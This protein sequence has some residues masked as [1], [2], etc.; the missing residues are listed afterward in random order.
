MLSSLARPCKLYWSS[1]NAPPSVAS[2]EQRPITLIAPLSVVLMVTVLWTP[3]SLAQTPPDAGVLQQQRQQQLERELLENLPKQAPPERPAAPPSESTPVNE[4]VLVTAYRFEGNTRLTETHLQTVVAPYLNRHMDLSALRTVTTMVAEYYREKGWLVRVYLPQQDV[5]GGT[6]LIAIQEARLG[7]VISE[8]IPSTRVKPERILET[9]TRQV[10]PDEYLNTRALDRGLLLAD[11]LAGVRVSGALEAGEGSGQ[12]NLRV[13]TAN[14]PVLR[15]D[16]SIDNGG[17]RATGSIRGIGNLRIESPLRQGDQLTLTTIFSEG[18]QYG[19]FGYLMPIGYDGWQVGLNASWLSYQLVA[20]EFSALGSEGNSQTVG[21]TGLY[22][23]IRTRNYNV[24][25]LMNYDYRRFQNDAVST[26]QSEYQIY[27]GT[28]GLTG[29]W[30]EEIL[31]TAGATFG[32]LSVVAGHVDQGARQ[33]G[34]NPD[35]AGAFTKLRW[36]V[37]RQQ[38]LR[39]WLSL[40]GAVTGQKGFSN[41]DAAERYYLGGPQSVRAYPVNE[42]GGSTGWL[43]TGELRSHLPWGFGLTGFF[44]V[45]RVIN[46]ATLGPSATLKGGGVTLSWRNPLGLACD[47]TWAHRL[48]DNPNPTATGTDQAGSFIRNRVWFSVSYTF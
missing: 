26:R 6:V 2:H 10:K 22:P 31:G 4:T 43:A 9:I 41:L 7:S 11:D 38:Q 15:G 40:Y 47:V 46:S 25:W 28:M 12:T 29:N 24:Q 30:F 20:P 23:L 5:T 44:D 18:S 8:G 16:M 32:S 45:G 21:L 27:E 39:P 42:A 36:Y 19:R 17:M 1:L 13:T 3:I 33:P 34:E 48:G 14:D 37:S 35:V